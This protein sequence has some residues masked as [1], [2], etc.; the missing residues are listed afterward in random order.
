MNAFALPFMQQALVALG[1]LALVSA[2]VGV[3]LNLRGLEFV[4][5]G[6]VHAVF[7]G[8]VIGFVTSGMP[9]LYVGAVIAALVATAALTWV[10]RRGSGTDATTAVVLAG[11]F[12][13]GIVIV[14]RTTNYATGL[15]HLLF[16]QLLT[17]GVGDIAAIAILGGVAL[18][19]VLATWKEQLFLSFDARG[20]RASGLPPIVYELALNLAIALV[21]VAAARA[22]GNLL[23]LAILIV[24]AAVGR[25]LSRRVGIISAIALGTALV[26]AVGGLW[27]AFEL[28]VTAGVPASPSSVVTL[29]YVG[30]Y[31]LAALA[32]SAI[33]RLGGDQRA[34]PPALTGMRGAVELRD[35]HVLGDAVPP[36]LRASSA[37]AGAGSG[38]GAP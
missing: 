17:V 31:L 34:R 32:S 35:D 21:V 30:V 29:V 33:A 10:S 28:S 19:L 16:G 24:P 22:V 37:G 13:I 14:S 38:A 1:L 26:G 3:H 12:A 5:D 23:V 20:A 9:G 27:L 25:L 11:T 18:V 6:L 7:P 4:S 15:E 36:G 2:V 8:V